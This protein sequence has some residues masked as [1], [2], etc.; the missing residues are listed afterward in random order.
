MNRKK[1]TVKKREKGTITCAFALVWLQFYF[2]CSLLLVF[3]L[4]FPLERWREMIKL[5]LHICTEGDAETNSTPPTS[6]SC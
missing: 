6:Q 2:H 1:L 5:I 3:S 4:F